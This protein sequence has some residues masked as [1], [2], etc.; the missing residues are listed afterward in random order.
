M[1]KYKKKIIICLALSFVLLSIGTTLALFNTYKDG[2][3][4]SKIR[5]GSLTFLYNDKNS[6][7]INISNATPISD[8][9]GKT[10][11]DKYTFSIES[12]TTPKSSVPY[13]VTARIKNSLLLNKIKVYLENEDLEGYNYTL[14]DNDVNY[15]NSLTNVDSKVQV[16]DGYIEKVIYEGSVPQNTSD[17][18][19]D[20]SV[21]MWLGDD[22]SV[23]TYSAYE[24]VLKDVSVDTTPLDVIALINNNQIIDSETYFNKPLNEQDLYERIAYVN[25]DLDKIITKSQKE[26]VG[27]TVPSGY[28]LSEQYY[29][30]NNKEITMQINVY[31]LG[32]DE[33]YHTIRYNTGTE[34]VL[35]PM[36][37]RFDEEIILPQL[38]PR[39]GFTFKGWFTQANGLGEE[40]VSPYSPTKNVTLNA[41][42]ETN[43]YNLTVLPNGGTWNNTT[44]DSVIELNY[45]ESRNIED[46]EKEGYTFNDWTLSGTASSISNKV[47]TMGTE[48]ATLSANY[49]VN[50]YPLTV[51]G[52]IEGENQDSIEGFGTFDLYINNE[53]VLDDAVSANLTLDYGTV[54][55]IN[56]IKTPITSK[57][58]GVKEGSLLGTVGVNNNNV[59]LEFEGREFTLTLDALTNGGE[60]QDNIIKTKAGVVS[61]LPSA[62]KSGWDFVG[63]NTD[64]LA[65]N[66]VN[67]YTMTTE[68]ITMYA[69]FKKDINIIFD[70]NNNNLTSSCEKDDETGI[71]TCSCRMYNND[72]SCQITTP[73]IL[74][75]VN[76]PTVIGFSQGASNHQKEIDA[77]ILINVSNS[78]T[79]YAQT[80]KEQITY[81]AT[82]LKGVGVSNIGEDSNSCTIASTYN[83]D[84]QAVSCGVTLPSIS[85]SSSYHSPVW[86]SSLQPGITVYLVQNQTFTATATQLT[87][88]DLSY[89]NSLNNSIQTVE[90]ALNYL[91]NQLK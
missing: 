66:G 3:N 83:G 41:Y 47:F 54:Y 23:L 21:R 38:T 34:E 53:L 81:T 28:T 18:N 85:V 20:F 56:D 26:M 40:I 39:L 30:L 33:T 32:Q 2:V 52:Y 8:S 31:S 1:K 80:V 19:N 89:T 73:T 43:K 15:F 65:T 11:N 84:S 46:P 64:P 17:Y 45:N 78:N 75:S 88:A 63:W 74:A 69:I 12:N 22:G 55:E 87:A 4:V 68:N 86:N 72:T 36:T 77:N 6:Q 29:P 57:Y 50:Q 10:Q 70:P 44:L 24:Y 62:T 37:V 5:V 48:P 51:N 60:V 82:Y 35:T 42:W 71:V 61:N 49:T 58:N 76:T 13:I 27:F 25:N 90:D 7:T 91:R 16:P 9:V 14:N 67:T 79:Y 59:R